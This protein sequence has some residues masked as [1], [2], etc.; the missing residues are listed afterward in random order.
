MVEA[1]PWHAGL[2]EGVAQAKNYAGMLA[3][4]FTYAATGQGVYAIDMETGIE[5]KVDVFSSPAELWART[6]ASANAWR[7]RFAAIPFEDLGGYF[8]GRYYQDIAVERVL[9]AIAQNQQRILLTLATGTGKTF[10]A[11]QLAW[12]LFKSRWN[13]LDWTRESE[14]TRRPRILFLADR[15]ILADQAYNAFSAFPEDALVRI[16]PAD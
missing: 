12:K 3:I 10:I 8:Q 13:L 5:G 6:F 2:T 14:P 9:D 15:N 11:F 4:R 1:K 16:E 7:D